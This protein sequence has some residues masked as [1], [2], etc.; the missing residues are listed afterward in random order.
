MSV[1]QFKKV[2]RELDSSFKARLKGLN[3]LELSN[4]LELVVLNE[5]ILNQVKKLNQ[6][7]KED[8]KNAKTK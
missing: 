4:E 7:L 6:L 3:T 2:L 5:L 1:K 8:I